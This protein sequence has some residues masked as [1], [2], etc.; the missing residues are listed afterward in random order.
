MLIVSLLVLKIMHMYL[1]ERIEHSVKVLDVAIRKGVYPHG[2][3]VQAFS[4]RLL[5]SSFLY[6]YVLELSTC[7]PT[8]L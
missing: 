3:L 2:A 7:L 5:D 8:K 4:K 1:N 6:Q